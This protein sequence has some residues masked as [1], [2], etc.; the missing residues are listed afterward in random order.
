MISGRSTR[1][2]ASGAVFDL[3]GTRSVVVDSDNKIHVIFCEELDAKFFKGKLMYSNSEDEGASWSTPREIVKT[4]GPSSP[5]LTMSPQDNTLFVAY[6]D[7]KDQAVKLFVTKSQDAGDNWEQPTMVVENDDS[8]DAFYPTIQVD[9]LNRIHL[10]WHEADR[11]DESP[12]T[13]NVYYTRSTDGAIEFDIPTRLNTVKTASAFSRFTLGGSTGSL[14]ATAWSD[15][16]NGQWDLMVARS[17]DA[18]QTWEELEA[19]PHHEG[20]DFNPDLLVT[21]TGELHLIWHNSVVNQN[22][23]ASY[24]MYA[25]SPDFGQTWNQPRLISTE[26]GRFPQWVVKPDSSAF[27]VFWLDE[28]FFGVNEVCP[29]PERCSDVAL[30][31]SVDGGQQWESIEFVQYEG[32]QSILHHSA[33]FFQDGR[34]VVVWSMQNSDLGAQRVYTKVRKAPLPF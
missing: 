23:P 31:Y 3:S 21:V 13:S 30:A 7:R 24:V 20:A 22:M 27:S 12:R 4:T 33:A 26:Q 18:G 32:H 8:I 6:L 28:K 9:D 16:R 14:L 17:S 15:F 10:T 11:A 34:P 2:Q 19:F 29:L 1:Y 25:S 5:Q